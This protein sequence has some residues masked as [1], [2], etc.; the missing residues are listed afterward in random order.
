MSLEEV[1]Y[2]RDGEGVLKV[3]WSERR[4]PLDLTNIK[5]ENEALISGKDRRGDK[6]SLT[7]LIP[8]FLFILC[9]F[10]SRN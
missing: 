1:W 3:Y 7:F 10:C 9:H 4:G 2:R 8:L 5:E 6:G